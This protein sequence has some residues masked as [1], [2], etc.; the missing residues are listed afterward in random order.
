M[1][2]LFI[3][4]L[5]ALPLGAANWYV[6][7]EA[8]GGAGNGQ[9]WAGAW[10]NFDKIVWASV[11]AGDTIN[12][13][14][15]PQ[16]GTNIYIGNLDDTSQ[17]PNSGASPVTI[18]AMQ[19][20]SHNGF[21]YQ[22]GHIVINATNRVIDGSLTAWT[23]GPK[24]DTYHVGTNCNWLVYNT[25]FNITSVAIVGVTATKVLSLQVIADWAPGPTGNAAI[26]YAGLSSTPLGAG[27]EI[28]YC[29]IIKSAAYGID[30]EGADTRIAKTFGQIAIH[31]NLIEGCCDNYT[32]I[33]DCADV[34][35]NVGRY[36]RAPDV[37]HPDT[38][39][40]MAEFYRSYDNTWVDNPGMSCYVQSTVG[41][42]QH[43]Y[44][45][46]NEFSYTS[47]TLANCLEI[48]GSTDPYTMCNISNVLFFNNTIHIQGYSTQ[49]PSVFLWN[50]AGVSTGWV[51]NL[52][53]MNNVIIATAPFNN[54]SPLFFPTNT[55]VVNGNEGWS[56][57]FTQVPVDYNC[58][59]GFSG[60]GKGICY[61]VHGDPADQFADMS[62]FAAGTP[63]ASNNNLTATFV[64][65][66]N[67]D[68]RLG[69]DT[70]AKLQG[71]NLTAFISGFGNL[72]EATNDI[73]GNARPA[74]GAWDIGAYQSDPGLVF[75]WSGNDN[76]FKD[77]SGHGNDP[78]QGN[79]T[80]KIYFTNAVDGLGMKFYQNGDHPAGG[81]GSLGCYA[82]VTPI[83]NTLFTNMTISLWAHG[84]ADTNSEGYLMD[85]GYDATQSAGFASSNSFAIKR[86]NHGADFDFH[87]WSFLIY[88]L[89]ES[90]G[91]NVVQWP[92]D[93]NSSFVST[94]FHLY[95]VTLSCT[96]H[97][98][99]AYYDGAPYMTNTVPGN[100]PY[101]KVYDYLCLGAWHHGES[102][103]WN[104][105]F[106]N[107]GYFAGTM[108]DP[109]IYN[110]QLSASEVAG[111]FSGAASS[112]SP[113]QGGGGG[114]VA[115]TST[116]TMGGGARMGGGGRMGQ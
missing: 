44:I 57:T 54:Q 24:A 75:W 68:Y 103:V 15:G 81:A 109:R 112:S 84:D 10:T 7:R 95:T 56:Y 77:D 110:R 14:G 50:R 35:K 1:K 98:A 11:N 90:G 62:A 40:F 27:S 34:Y 4:L 105:T 22:I 37:G 51:T 26:Q 73:N 39:Q 60:N 94:N 32:Q 106:P 47:N 61:G 16:G 28:A 69:A 23:P 113:A 88:N 107:A 38:Q 97:Q 86:S 85:A 64:S 43:I 25:N 46:N 17:N 48:S 80:N 70:A 96:S 71:T 21:I 13:S 31:H 2:W 82:Y 76:Q 72:P 55:T 89:G 83:T 104:G 79:P 6:A 74:S 92:I 115:S 63:F 3:L 65:L 49:Q 66:T 5:T 67:H 36:K 45:Y 12:V 41:T 30:I 108:D 78:Y 99:I 93:M 18:K 87:H 101:I 59:S 53:V 100:V 33:K 42:N 111:L 8:Y 9:S 29:W 52:I 116:A 102:W 20:S 114:P 58:L 19:D 91:S